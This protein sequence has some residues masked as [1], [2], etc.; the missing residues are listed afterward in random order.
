M[1]GPTTAK[2]P[3]MQEALATPRR[4][5]KQLATGSP[6]QMSQG[7]NSIWQQTGEDGAKGWKP[8]G[9]IG[10]IVE[11][12]PSFHEREAE[13][14]EPTIIGAMADVQKHQPTSI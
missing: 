14:D 4:P 10:A 5:M 2:T 7:R 9:E 1:V 12:A 13:D 8:T 3:T 6:E 11:A